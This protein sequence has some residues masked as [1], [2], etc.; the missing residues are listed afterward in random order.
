MR[1]PIVNANLN[2][3]D[4]SKEDAYWQSQFDKEHYYVPGDTWDDYRSAYR[5]GYEG[6]DRYRGRPYVEVE[7]NLR[8]DWERDRGTTRATW[9][10]VKHAVKAAWHRMEHAM[11]GDAGDDGH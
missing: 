1:R 2:P 8:A 3:L 5:A 7:G 4:P 9:D 6:Y 11:P 10:K